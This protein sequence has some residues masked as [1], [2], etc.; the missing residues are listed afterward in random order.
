MVIKFS[1]IDV[2]IIIIMTRL[3]FNRS[4]ISVRE[5]NVINMHAPTYPFVTLHN[6][7]V[8]VQSILNFVYFRRFLII[9]L[10]YTESL[11]VITLLI[12]FE[13]HSNKFK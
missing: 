13:L 4:E 8:T 5:K 12:D 9:Y 7:K 2:I 3:F 6:H 10:H 11:S 1:S